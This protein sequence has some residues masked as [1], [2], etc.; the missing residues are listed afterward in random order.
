MALVSGILLI[1]PVVGGPV[2]EARA[3]AKSP[4]Y[5]Y[6]RLGDGAGTIMLKSDTNVIRTVRLLGVVLPETPHQKAAQKEHRKVLDEL[7]SG[8]KVRLEFEP[9]PKAG[10]RTD[11]FHVYRESDGLWIN[12][13][14]IRTGHGAADQ[15][16]QFAAAA[17]FRAETEKAR[18]QEAGLWSQ[19]RFA[20]IAQAFDRD[21]AERQGNQLR[22]MDAI[23]KSKK[24][25]A[26]TIAKM[27]EPSVVPLP[28][29]PAPA[30]PPIDPE[31]ARAQDD[32]R[33]RRRQ[34]DRELRR[35]E[36]ERDRARDRDE[37]DRHEKELQ[38]LRAREEAQRRDFEER[39]QRLKDKFLGGPAQPG[40][41]SP[42]GNPP[43]TQ[44]NP[45]D[46]GPS[47]KGNPPSGQPKVPGPGRSSRGELPAVGGPGMAG[48][49]K[50]V[51]GETRDPDKSSRTKSGPEQSKSESS[52]SQGPGGR[53][54]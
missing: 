18:N 52:K 3:Q 31:F 28:V 41:P 11:T 21:A 1:A 51:K 45:S 24:D 54:P 14:L 22:Q 30:A 34:F 49:P 36:D 37:R 39:L 35:R 46:G 48:I 40:G 47:P 17:E 50:V 5:E 33:E 29:V 9:K 19:E 4:S 27:V 44:P 42:K 10:T 8:Q 20:A 13:E 26:D 32:E 38:E 2:G 53:R 23:R 43:T 25:R 12:R 15:T 16:A 7:L 6:V